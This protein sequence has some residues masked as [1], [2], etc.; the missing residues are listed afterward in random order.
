MHP[1]GEGVG[2]GA[3]TF[4]VMSSIL[5]YDREAI[6]LCECKSSLYIRCFTNVDVIGWYA[7]LRACPIWGFSRIQWN[8][9]ALGRT[10]T[11]APISLRG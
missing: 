11:N 8:L 1:K 9:A 4:V 6:S 5:H 10:L 3:A 7:S 2:S